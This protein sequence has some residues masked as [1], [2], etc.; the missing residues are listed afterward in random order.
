M[1]IQADLL[2]TNVIRP[3]TT[4]TTALGVAFLAGLASGFWK[5]RKEIESLWEKDREFVP[6]Q[7]IQSKKT[8]SL[9]QERISKIITNES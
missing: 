8:I 2:N 7:N 3:K 4:E 6:N 5:S 1:Q 9:W